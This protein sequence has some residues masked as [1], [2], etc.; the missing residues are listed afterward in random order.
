MNVTGEAVKIKGTLLP[1]ASTETVTKAA[2][3]RRWS[4]R[5]PNTAARTL[6]RRLSRDRV[7]AEPT[8]RRDTGRRPDPWCRWRAPP[9]RRTETHHDRWCVNQAEIE[10]QRDG[11]PEQTWDIDVRRFRVGDERD[12][13]CERCGRKQPGALRERCGASQVRRDEGADARDQAD[14]SPREKQQV[15]LPVRRQ[16]TEAPEPVEEEQRAVDDREH[17]VV[18]RRVGVEPVMQKYGASP[19]NTSIVVRSFSRQ[20]VSDRRRSRGRW[21]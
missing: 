2:D 8:A 12:D 6:A 3:Q 11:K 16:H 21:R 7:R 10:D 13:K 19:L 15:V 14:H 20:L 17:V 18:E 4:T 5:G 1:S 9:T